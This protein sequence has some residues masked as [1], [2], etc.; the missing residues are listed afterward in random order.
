MAVQNY[1]CLT[2]ITS[3]TSLKQQ[4][5]QIPLVEFGCSLLQEHLQLSKHAVLKL[6][7]FSTTYLQKAGFSR[8]VGTK[9]KHLCRVDVALNMKINQLSLPTLKD[10]MRQRK[11]SCFILVTC[12]EKLNV[13]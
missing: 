9:S 5:S 4:F 1:K 7:L 3:D 11:K 13:H 8:Y 6:L 10:F 12:E 2:D